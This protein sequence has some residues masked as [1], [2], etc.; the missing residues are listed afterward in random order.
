M[1]YGQK[2][3]YPPTKEMQNIYDALMIDIHNIPAL[4][5]LIPTVFFSSNKHKTS[6]GCC[7]FISRKLDKEDIHISISQYTPSDHIKETIIHELAHAIS[8]SE[9]GH[10]NVFMSNFSK[11]LRML[12]ITNIKPTVVASGLEALAQGKY[13]I[14]CNRCN[15]ISYRH[16]RTDAFN[17]PERYKCSCGGSIKCLILEDYADKK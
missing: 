2:G 13:A 5:S 1:N 7:A 8:G 12:S 17:N 14:I 16:K 4:Q 11:L 9:Q 3:L 10:N 6:L 15:K